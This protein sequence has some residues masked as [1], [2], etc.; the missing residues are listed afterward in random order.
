MPMPDPIKEVLIQE[1]TG[2]QRYTAG[3]LNRSLAAEVPILVP[4]DE[5]PIPPPDFTG[6]ATTGD[7]PRE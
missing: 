4:Q 1:D 6:D 7:H 3:S 2:A 5:I